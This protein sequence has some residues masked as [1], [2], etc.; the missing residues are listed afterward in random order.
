MNSEAAE[1]VLELIRAC[2]ESNNS[3]AWQQFIARFHRPISLS[4]MRTARRW[5]VLPQEIAADLIQ[6]TYLRLCDGKCELLYKFAISHPEAIEGYIKTIAANVAHDHFKSRLAT[7]HGAGAVFQVQ[8][9]F[10]PESLS[11]SI[12][13]VEAIQRSV[14]LREIEQCLNACTEGPTQE[15]D[16]IIFWLYYQQGLTAREIAELPVVAMSVKGVESAVLRLTRQ[17][18]EGL[19]SNGSRTAQVSPQVSRGEEKGFRPIKS[20]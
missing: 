20:Y 5:G 8:D 3:D 14:L 15:R 10:D 4:V 6:E 12:G 18:R 16:R 17:V 19:E 13:G 1:H 7:K 2:V 9:G 11:E